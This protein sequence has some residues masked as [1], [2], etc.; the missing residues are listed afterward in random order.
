[1]DG[2]GVDRERGECRRGEQPTA[3]GRVT[4]ARLPGHGH[5]VGLLDV[6][7]AQGHA[8]GRGVGSSGP[9]AQG[10]VGRGDDRADGAG[11]GGALRP[12]NFGD[13]LTECSAGYPPS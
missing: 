7:D 4:R 6:P 11:V 8:D 13:P 3:C 12:V 10:S 9:V 5:S 1:M 2:R